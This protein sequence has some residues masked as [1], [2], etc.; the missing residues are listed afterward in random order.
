MNNKNHKKYPI[1]QSPLFKLSCHGRLAK[2]LQIKPATLR[3][4]I[5]RADTNYFFSKI[6]DTGR[7]LQVPK[8]QLKRVH[9]RLYS[10]LSRVEAPDYL[11][12]GVKKRSN[13]TNAKKHARSVPAIKIDIKSFYRN[14]KEVYVYKAFLNAYK[15]SHDIAVTLSKLCCVSGFVPTGSPISQSVAYLANKGVFD[16]IN[17]YSRSRGVIFSLY[18]DDLTF[19]GAAATKAFCDYVTSYIHKSRGYECHKIRMYNAKTPKIITGVVVQNGILRVRNKERKIISEL[20]AQLTQDISCTAELNK[21]EK[22]VRGFHKLIGHLSSVG[23]FNGRYRQLMKNWI[24]FRKELK[25]GAANQNSL[26][27]LREYSS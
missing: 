10:L 5:K 7:E 3:G 22:I 24:D 8:P 14:T 12:S 25:I 19:S 4:L 21:S 26:K 6:A 1:N 17:L 13:V 15:C 27:K 9:A 18:V 11:Q 23:Q 2:I 16:H 20:M